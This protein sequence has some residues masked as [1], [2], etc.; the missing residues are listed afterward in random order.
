MIVDCH[1]HFNTKKDQIRNA[2]KY[3]TDEWAKRIY[4]HIIQAPNHAEEATTV[5]AWIES[6]DRYGVDKIILQVAPFGGNDAVGEFARQ[7]PDRFIGVA[8]IDFIDPQG[9]NSVQELER[10]VTD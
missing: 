8:N 4:G 9:S 10:C 6:L 1:G 3:L 5:E 2:K 7:K